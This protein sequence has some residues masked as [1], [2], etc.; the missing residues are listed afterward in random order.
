MRRRLTRAA[1][2]LLSASLALPTPGVQAAE[3]KRPGTC[4]SGNCTDG[5]GSLQFTHATYT[6]S[7]VN[8]WFA[9]G[10]Y[11]VVYA[12][13]PTQAHELTIDASGF[14]L[15]GTTQRG[16]KDD[17]LR[18]PTLYTG[19]FAK[20]WNPFGRKH[21]PRYAQGR[22][23]DAS[24]VVYEGEFDFVPGMSGTVVGGYY[25]F[26]GVRIDEEADEVSSG[27]YI[28]DWTTPDAPVT[29]YPSYLPVVFH[30]ARPDYVA[31]L[32]DD[33]RADLER[34]NADE[35]AKL[36][37][38][39]ES[40]E[41]WNTLF[42][43]AL[44]VAAVVGTAKLVSRSSAAPSTVTTL[45]DTL[46]SR[47]SAP[48]ASQKMVAEVR[49][50]A[51]T[52]PML[53]RRIGKASDAEVAAM[54]REAGRAP[55]QKMT[56]A[57]YR[58]ATTGKPDALVASA[59]AAAAQEKDIKAKDEKA[60]KQAE[61]DQEARAQ[62]GAAAAERTRK[63][64]EAEAA[65][66]AAQEAAQE[67]EDQARRDYLDALSRG[68]KLRART[69]PGGEGQYYVVGILPTVKPKK[70]D[71]LDLHYRAQCVGSAAYSDG[72]GKTFLGISTD[73][74]MG[75]TYKI[76]PKPACPLDQLKVTV[77]EIRACGE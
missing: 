48:A 35:A 76:E 8:S 60:K 58:S 19:T 24:G 14:P 18:D 66:K 22:Y 31:K 53:A 33:L 3:R 62:A 46:A 52:D 64:A 65:K 47:Q 41:N 11:S 9:A 5:N 10:T 69:C 26:Q 7:W 6:G 72:V 44:G 29:E 75:D 40:R 49:E 67:T 36:A 74:F 17:R 20:V 30:R 56:V 37:R 59:G 25:I 43:T 23:A 51:K 28:S 1:L 42:A 21:M 77:K 63:K 27:L 39:R 4:I 54:L 61:R 38:E 12:A 73:C 34:V 70:V 13:Y 45:G 68:T 71:C 55:P 57:E 16:A 2:L 50:R 32:Q 15:K